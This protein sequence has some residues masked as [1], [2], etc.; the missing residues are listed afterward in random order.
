MR[1]S[2]S[3]STSTT[4]TG[5]L[6][7]I[8]S[9]GTA[10]QVLTSNGAG[11]L[12]TMQNAATGATTLVASSSAA[13]SATLDFDDVFDGTYDDYLIVYDNGVHSAASILLLRVGTGTG[14]VTYQATNYHNV[15]YSDAGTVGANV[16]ISGTT[17]ATGT[18][19]VVQGLAC[20]AS[21]SFPASGSFMVSSSQKSISTVVHSAQ[22]S[23]EA[24]GNRYSLGSGGG[25]Y[26]P[27]TTVTSF[28]LYADSGNL[29]TL[30]VRVYGIEKP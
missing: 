23:F 7:S 15:F 6:Q 2:G 4:G 3:S 13:A 1:R 9:V 30:E 24:T 5:A 12:P 27:T 18:Y 29:T 10:G 25:C 11:A 14:P 16:T 19:A 22:S 26:S 28:R 21:S 17:A 20:K 8:A